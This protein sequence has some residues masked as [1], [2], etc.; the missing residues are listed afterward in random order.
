MTETSILPISS[1]EGQPPSYDSQPP[2]EDGA[3]GANRRKLLIAGG[4]AGAV[5]IAAA[6]FL[7]LHGGSSA[8][9]AATVIPHGTPRAAA[10][11]TKAKSVSHSKTT[12]LPK[13]AKANPGRNPFIPLYIAPV[14]GGTAA[15]PTTTVSSAPSPTGTT[16]VTTVPTPAPTAPTSGLGNP[17]YIQLLST[18]GSQQATFRV[19]YPHHKFKRFVVDAPAAHSDTGTVFD[20][21]FALL[22]VKD[23]IATI[24][25]G[26]GVPFQLTTGIARTTS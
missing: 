15:G 22:S 14:T 7:L 23:G 19:G 11:V 18:K 20:T 4:V 24:Q 9:P 3:A 25:V 16:P 17:T 21:E 5:V 10:P 2:E 13:K 12:T 26:D 6:A 1:A 8:S